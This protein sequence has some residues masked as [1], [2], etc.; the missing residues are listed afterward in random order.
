MLA[1]IGMI[2]LIYTMYLFITSEKEGNKIKSTLRRLYMFFA[3]D[4]LWI[5]IFILFLI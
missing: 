3:I 4:L 1:L 2:L 5:I